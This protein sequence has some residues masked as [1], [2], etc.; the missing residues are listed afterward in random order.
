MLKLKLVPVKELQ[1]RIRFERDVLQICMFVDRSFEEIADLLREYPYLEMAQ[2][3]LE[4]MDWPYCL[5][6]EDALAIV[7]NSVPAVWD[8]W[9]QLAV[10]SHQS[11]GT[12]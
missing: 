5:N 4:S 6:F 7:Q 3:L 9:R 8:H 1:R 11:S 10:R 12:G 2:F